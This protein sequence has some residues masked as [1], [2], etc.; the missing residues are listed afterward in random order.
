MITED[1]GAHLETCKEN[2]LQNHMLQSP[3]LLA[4]LLLAPAT[5]TP[6]TLPV[7]WIKFMQK[8]CQALLNTTCLLHL[9]HPRFPT[10]T[11]SHVLQPFCVRRSPCKCNSCSSLFP[12]PST[13]CCAYF[14]ST[15]ARFGVSLK[16]AHT[17]FQQFSHTFTLLSQ[18]YIQSRNFGFRVYA[19]FTHTLPKF[20]V[21]HRHN[22]FG[23]VPMK[24]P[25][26]IIYFTL[27][28]LAFPLKHTRH[29]PRQPLLQITC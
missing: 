7:Q 23:S 18:E 6:A 19:R 16:L 24:C 2:S 3:N 14:L 17:L 10:F 4:G 11:S 12:T 1:S 20:Q 21:C 27:S 26:S 8:L 13:P 25:H 22:L 5:E 15:H 28:C 9:L 29:F